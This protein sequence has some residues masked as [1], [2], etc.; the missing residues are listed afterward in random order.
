[1]PELP[2]VETI[3]RDLESVLVGT[4]I[5]EVEFVHDAGVFRILRRFPSRKVFAREVTGRT[6]EGVDRRG[7]YL[8][9]RL[10]PERI[11]LLHLGMTGQLLFRPVTTAPDRFARVVFRLNGSKLEFADARKFGELYLYRPGHYEAIDL[12]RLGP[13]PLSRDLSRAYLSR[14]FQGRKRAIKAVL[15]DQ[16]VVAGIGN[17]YSDEI[18][19]AAG[20]D[21]RRPAGSL[22][23]K[24]I[25]RLY[26]AITGILTRAVER[27]G[28]SARDEWFV[29]ARGRPGGFQAELK[30]YQRKD[31]LCPECGE[32]V[33]RETIGGRS[34]H[35]CPR[36]QK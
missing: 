10:G 35:F 25:D 17:I 31:D 13:E 18:L 16:S 4:R 34:A 2:E 26:R 23:R 29:D 7:K 33:V 27:R 22:T 28:T 3:R 19:F 12:N 8:L 6:I 15:L 1:M 14:T 24:E 9:F 11:L 5:T 30:V 21:P 32:T 20:I 36:C